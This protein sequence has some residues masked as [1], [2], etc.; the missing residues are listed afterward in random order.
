MPEVSDF[1]V[2]FVGAAA[3]VPLV[4]TYEPPEQLAARTTPANAPDRA[5]SWQ[6]PRR[7]RT[8]WIDL[9]RPPAIFLTYPA[10]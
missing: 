9:L 2:T 4:L 5:T 10:K 7:D 6:K 3:G 1:P 8:A